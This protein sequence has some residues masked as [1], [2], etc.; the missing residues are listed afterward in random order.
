MANYNK[1][2]KEIILCPSCKGEGVLRHHEI[3][4]YHRNE[5]DV[6]TTECVNCDGKGRLWLITRM[7]LQKL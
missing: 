4:D 5:Y 1:Y 7:E 2:N 6:I 3:T